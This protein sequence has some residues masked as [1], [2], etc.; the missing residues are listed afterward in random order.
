MSGS[1]SL[2]SRKKVLIALKDYLNMWKASVGSNVLNE[3]KYDESVKEE[4]VKEDNKVQ[5]EEQWSSYPSPNPNNGN[6]QVPMKTPS[7][8][9]AYS[10]DLYSNEP[11]L[12]ECFDV[13][14][15]YGKS[16]DS[17]V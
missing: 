7:H 5:E 12:D 9:I 1:A 2:T 8:T 11:I 13:D 10:E 17:W 14:S 16:Y 4:Q 6:T 3:E 15:F